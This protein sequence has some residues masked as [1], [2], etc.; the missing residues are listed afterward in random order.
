LEIYVRNDE[1]PHTVPQV[2]VLRTKKHVVGTDEW[3]EIQLAR[4]VLEPNAAASKVAVALNAPIAT[5]GP[6]QVLSHALAVEKAI[7]PQG[8]VRDLDPTYREYR[9][10]TFMPGGLT[11]DN[12]TTDQVLDA[13]L[14]MADRQDLLL[15]RSRGSEAKGV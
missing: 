10:V 7:L 2:Y 9:R 15:A 8:C 3:P 14:S 1:K 11:S 12:R 6:P 5:A 4:I 13:V